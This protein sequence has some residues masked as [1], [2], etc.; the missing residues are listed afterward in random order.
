[1]QMRGQPQVERALRHALAQGRVGHALLF[2]G[3][4][5]VG[6][7]RAAR[8]LARALVC[9]RGPAEQ[10]FGC[11]ACGPCRRAEAGS[12]PD[13]HWVRSE[14]ES[15]DLGHIAA[16]GSGKPAR[17]ILVGQIRELSRQLRMR[18]YEGRA[19]VAILTHADRMNDNAAN[20]L[21]KTLEEPRDGAHLI[22]LATQPRRLP[23]TIASR[24]QVLRFTPLPVEVVAQILADEGTDHPER[25]AA[26]C[27]GSLSRARALSPSDLDAT[28]QQRD[29]LD[30]VLSGS[31]SARLQ[32]VEQV[33]RDREACAEF[34]TAL[35]RA[36]REALLDPERHLHRQDTYRLLDQ[37]DIA[38]DGLSRSAHVQMALEEVV[39]STGP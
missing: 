31:A 23:A 4:H 34:L 21:L 28:A 26:L 36:C 16:S 24:C 9:E 15:V 38:R 37:I 2:L 35:E 33:G 27:G 17:A 3:P 1:M 10:T 6:K 5:G 11:G 22:L 8:L 25:R 14:A 30:V 39:L 18:P 32:L 29:F 13:I 7:T 12:H 20:A 19:Q